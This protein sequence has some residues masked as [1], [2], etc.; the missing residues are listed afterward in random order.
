VAAVPD[1]DATSRYGEALIALSVLGARIV[2][3]W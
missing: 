3:R 2:E 1:N